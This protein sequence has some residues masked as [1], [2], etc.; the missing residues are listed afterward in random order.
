M[1]PSRSADRDEM[2]DRG[3]CDLQSVAEE[4]TVAPESMTPPLEPVVVAGVNNDVTVIHSAQ[5]NIVTALV[6]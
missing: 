4:R 3:L 2:E 5:A 1:E 6:D